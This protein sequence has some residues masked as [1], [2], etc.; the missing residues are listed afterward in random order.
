MDNHEIHNF[1]DN[2]QEKK[3]DK[4][5]ERKNSVL[6]YLRDL[7]VLLT[8][9]LLVFVLLF[10]IV[11][12]SGSSMSS[13][14]VDGDYILLLNNVFY[15]EP[16]Q[17][18]VIVA[19]KETFKGGEPIIKRV[20]AT[21]GQTVEYDGQTGIVKVDGVA[22]DEPYIL[23]EAH[24]KESSLITVVE[25]GCVFV[26]GDNRNNSNDSRYSEIGQVDTR[27]ILG[28]AVIIFLPGEIFGERDFS[29]I[30]VLK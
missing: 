11:I 8:I 19:T 6:A 14:L 18:D 30:G 29:R 13:T 12:V 24:E 28:K 26:M 7:T 15:H 23:Q 22:L 21:E 16:K 10:R 1:E 25:D 3:V 5:A 27:E 20:I 2:I 4:I 17:G 9:V